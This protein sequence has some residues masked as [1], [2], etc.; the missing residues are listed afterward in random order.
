MKQLMT[1]VSALL[2]VLVISAGIQCVA[3]GPHVPSCEG[4]A[5]ASDSH[6]AGVPRTCCPCAGNLAGCEITQGADARTAI[7]ST[8]QLPVTPVASLVVD[9][10][11]ALL[12]H[13]GPIPDATSVLHTTSCPI[14]LNNLSLLC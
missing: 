13:G 11:V 4:T 6:H 9:H 14:Y 3:A 8:L 5:N 1:G 12:S 7:T 2:L 10:M